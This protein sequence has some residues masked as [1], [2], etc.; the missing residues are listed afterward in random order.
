MKKRF[1]VFVLS[2]AIA[3]L[4]LGFV[5]C[6]DSPIDPDNLPSSITIYVPDGPPL[7]ALASI[8]QNTP[9][10]QGVN[11]NIERT[12]GALI[13]GHMVAQRPDI[14]LVPMNLAANRF[15][16]DGEYVLAGVA[17]WGL[18]HIV[19]NIQEAD[20]NV[21]SSLNDLVGQTIV[22]YQRNM[23]PGIVL[24]TVLRENGLAV[25]WLLSES[26]AINPDAVN[27]IALADNA[28]ANAALGGQNASLP[29][30]R[31]A[32]LAEPVASIRESQANFRR[33]FDLN[34]E[35]AAVFD[36]EDFDARIPQVGV[37]VRA[38]LARYHPAFVSDVM[39][40]IAGS[41]DF[42]REYPDKAADLILNELSSIY[43]PNNLAV[44]TSFL[45][46]TGQA[47]YEFVHADEAQSTVL[48]FL[49]IL[50][51]TNPSFVGGSVPTN[52][53]FMPR[54]N[55]RPPSPPNC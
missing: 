53:F 31:F 54:R 16:D 1:V 29:N 18:L 7:I 14:A 10:V 52:D 44:V 42:V 15:N 24:E 33:A 30:T 8:Y 46:S 19:E 49:N 28:A 17:L 4:A 3:M 55:T 22:A 37:V 23:S 40:L 25:N 5:A 51:Q 50:Y 6:D 9:S 38:S 11:I 48:H 34:E 36:D 20:G 13:G 43:I 12:T 41:I 27:I 35:W 26:A 47:V 21:A 2:L 32:L 39:D 45:S